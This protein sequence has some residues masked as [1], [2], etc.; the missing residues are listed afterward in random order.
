MVSSDRIKIIVNVREQSEEWP[1]R[2][3]RFWRS[4][5][6]AEQIE[7]A[8]GLAS[9]E[10]MLCNRLG[11][12]LIEQL[13]GKLIDSIAEPQRALM[14]PTERLLERWFF[15]YRR[16][17]RPEQEWSAP[18]PLEALL[19]TQREGFANHPIIRQQ[20]SKL[21]ALSSVSASVV[22]DGYSSIQLGLSMEPINKIAEIFDNDFDSF[23]VFLEAFVPVSIDAVLPVSVLDEID[24][25]VHLPD[26]IKNKFET[27]QPSLIVQ[28]TT[29]ALPL[30]AAAREKAEWLWRLANGSLLVPVLLALA[31]A[32]FGVQILLDINYRSNEMMKPI[33]EHHLKLLEED[34]KRIF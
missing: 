13:R 14:A 30:Q 22:I 24:C 20:L 7:E 6:T 5:L 23:R 28:P 15:E 31:V 9:L 29:T 33:L 18:F 10:G 2:R 3:S 32:Y 19:S 4:L 1:D 11:G 25:S 27:K 21:A 17:V 26:S 34:R 8:S 12:A 16:K